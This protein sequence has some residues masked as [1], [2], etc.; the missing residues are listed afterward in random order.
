MFRRWSIAPLSLNV[1]SS[2]VKFQAK[3]GFCALNAVANGVE[4]PASMYDL[5]W[6]ESVL[7]VCVGTGQ[8]GS[9]TIAVRVGTGQYGSVTV[10]T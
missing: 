9:V 4:L 7:V 3:T 8:Y 5:V 10:Q 6:G 2:R 1:S